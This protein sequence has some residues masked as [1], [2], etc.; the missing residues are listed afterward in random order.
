MSLRHILTHGRPFLVLVGCCLIWLGMP[1][2]ARPAPPSQTPTLTVLS[3]PSSQTTVAA[4][5]ITVEVDGQALSAVSVTNTTLGVR[6]PATTSVVGPGKKGSHFLALNVRL[7]PG[8]NTLTV[9]GV[10]DDGTPVSTTLT[11]DTTQQRSAVS[12]APEPAVVEGTPGQVTF[13]VQTEL[14]GTPVELL[15]DQDGDGSIDEVLDFTASPSVAYDTF[16]RFMPLVTVRTET[17]LLFTNDPARTLPVAVVPPSLPDPVQAFNIGSN[18][19]DLAYDWQTRRLY[20]LSGSEATVRLFETSGTLVRTIPL[21]GATTPQGMSVDAEGNLYIADTGTTAFSSCSPVPTLR[22]IR[23]WVPRGPL[24]SKAVG[25]GSSSVRTMSQSARSRRRPPSL[26]PTPA[27][28]A[29]N[30]LTVLA[31][32]SWTSTAAQRRWG[33]CWH[34]A[35]CSR[36]G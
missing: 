29:S 2:A 20:V 23:P 5:A 1:P 17:N 8:T 11:V 27:T 12:I 16:G 21:P 22:R 28:T 14:T 25:R 33:L 24:A 30:G 9:D 13:H 15:L 31:C 7:G 32:L 35:D 34:R 6:V 36:S 18:P 26:S 3:P 10:A 4:Y 19:V